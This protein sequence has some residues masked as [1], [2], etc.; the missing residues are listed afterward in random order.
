MNAANVVLK[1]RRKSWQPAV[2]CLKHLSNPAVVFF[3][4][5]GD[6]RKLNQKQIRLHSDCLLSSGKIFLQ[7]QDYYS[8]FL[9][10]LA[11][12][13][14]RECYFIFSS[15]SHSFTMPPSFPL[16]TSFS[17]SFDRRE[18][19]DF[20]FGFYTFFYL[21]SHSRDRMIKQLNHF[22]FALFGVSVQIGKLQ[23]YLSTQ[24]VSIQ[25]MC[26]FHSESRFWIFQIL[27]SLGLCVYPS[28]VFLEP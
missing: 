13:G 27:V 6:H 17:S 12:R 1:F 21:H 24:D 11:S 22:L 15:A 18:P 20:E 19:R 16:S 14:L 3:A 8:I 9:H 23:M 10:K 28:S 7:C 2:L 26:P 25:I 5:L 4:I